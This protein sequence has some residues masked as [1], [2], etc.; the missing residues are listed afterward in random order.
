MH[1]FLHY[2]YQ[3]FYDNDMHT[4]IKCMHHTYKRVTCLHRQDSMS[5]IVYINLYIFGKEKTISV[6]VLF[7]GILNEEVRFKCLKHIQN[8][9]NVVRRLQRKMIGIFNKSSC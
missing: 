4:C 8:N 2:I 7:K 5:C 9:N 1:V 3:L 6:A